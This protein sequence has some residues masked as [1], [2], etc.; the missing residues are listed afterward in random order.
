MP[1]SGD[2]NDEESEQYAADE[3]NGSQEAR[4]S[5][6]LGPMPVEQYRQLGIPHF[7]QLYVRGF[8]KGGSYDEIPL[9]MNAYALEEQFQSNPR[10]VFSV[11]REVTK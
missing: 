2:S 9:A 10:R 3:A 5:L 6:Y 8:L 1:L 4:S 7:A 11:Q